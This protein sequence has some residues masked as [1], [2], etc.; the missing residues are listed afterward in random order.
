MKSTFKFFFCA[1]DNGGGFHCFHITAKD[2]ADAIR[3][4]IAKAGKTAKGDLLN[5]ECSFVCAG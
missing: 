1:T 2:K 5:W 3:K 4:G